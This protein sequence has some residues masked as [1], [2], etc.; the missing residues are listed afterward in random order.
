LPAADIEALTAEMAALRTEYGQVRP[1]LTQAA[2]EA[3]VDQSWVPYLKQVQEMSA[4]I[5]RGQA[6][7]EQLKRELRQI[8]LE[9]GQRRARWNFWPW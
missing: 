1:D 4:N 8:W 7:N 3:A 6:E 5:D 9:K 2:V